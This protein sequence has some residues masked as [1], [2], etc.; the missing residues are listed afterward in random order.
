[1]EI[2]KN[3]MLFILAII[4]AFFIYL[5]IQKPG[6][7][8]FASIP[9]ALPDVAAQAIKNMSSKIDDELGTEQDTYNNDAC[10]F[11]DSDLY[12]DRLF[13]DENE[14]ITRNMI[15]KK[16]KDIGKGIKLNPG[17]HYTVKCD[18][19]K[20]YVYK[21]E[22][23]QCSPYGYD[24]RYTASN[25]LGVCTAIGYSKPCDQMAKILQ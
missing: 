14:S 16:E 12:N 25:S 24:A 9:I 4:I 1:M 10:I 19:C 18:E 22:K 20:K 13:T 15:E 23:G 21:D 5:F 3:L 2:F 7:I 11:L 17:K 6:E 8:D